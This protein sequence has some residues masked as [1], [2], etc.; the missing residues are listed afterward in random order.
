MSG[1][2]DNTS[3]PQ[4]PQQP[5]PDRLAAGS[6]FCKVERGWCERKIHSEPLVRSP[7]PPEFLATPSLHL[8]PSLPL[9]D[10]AVHRLWFEPRCDDVLSH[11]SV[12][13]FT[14]ED[15]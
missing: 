3:N 15:V 4:T 5:R 13:V 7:S 12:K 9:D 6:F 10:L 1:R 11:S 8:H 2:A 14:R